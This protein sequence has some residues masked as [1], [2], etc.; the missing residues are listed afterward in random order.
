MSVLLFPPG[1]MPE[2]LDF[3]QVIPAFFCSGWFDFVLSVSE[4]K[5]KRNEKCLES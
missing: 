2:L 3:L 4:T 1:G 5:Q